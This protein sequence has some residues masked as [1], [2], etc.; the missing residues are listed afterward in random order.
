M[1][2]KIGECE[3]SDCGFTA[4]DV[5]LDKAGHPYVVCWG[6]ECEG[7]QYFTHGKGPRVRAVIERMKFRPLPG[8]NVA[9]LRARY[10]LDARPGPAPAPEPAPA[11]APVPPAPAA[12][13]KT[14]FG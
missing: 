4:C 3:C 9:E 1:K 12:K 14:I 8:V 7:A 2:A 11:P 5:G 10:G 13:R 6:K